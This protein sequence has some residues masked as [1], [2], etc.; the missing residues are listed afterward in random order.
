MDPLFPYL[1]KNQGNY[2]KEVRISAKSAKFKKTSPFSQN[3]FIESRFLNE[4]TAP[5]A[6]ISMLKRFHSEKDI[7]IFEIFH[8]RYK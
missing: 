7:K 1:R 4:S 3:L 8:F 5:L 2:T 6:N